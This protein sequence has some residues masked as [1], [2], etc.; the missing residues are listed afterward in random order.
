VALHLGCGAVIALLGVVLI[1]LVAPL[2]GSI[3]LV[4]A[5]AARSLLAPRRPIF[6]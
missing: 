6:G 1:A 4:T 2:F 3:A 5:A